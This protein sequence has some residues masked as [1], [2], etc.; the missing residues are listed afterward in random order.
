MAG[1]LASIPRAT[2]LKA[3]KD[4]E[5]LTWPTSNGHKPAILL[6]ELKKVY[7]LNYTFQAITLPQNVQ[8]EPW[9]LKLNPQGKIPV[10]V[11]HDRDIVVSEC[12]SMCSLFHAI[13]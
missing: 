10:V 5:L 13:S 6:E 4:L 9:F 12:S 11:D 3:T 2:G 1:P 8:K 7:S